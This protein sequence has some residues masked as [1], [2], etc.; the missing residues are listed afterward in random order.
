MARTYRTRI[1]KRKKKKTKRRLIILSFLL[2]CAVIYLA[3]PSGMRDH[4]ENQLQA[5][6][7]KNSLKQRRR[8]IKMKQKRTLSSQKMI[9]LNWINI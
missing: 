7:K 8:Q 9:M 4:Q 3:L 2:V 1:K 6:E 5:T